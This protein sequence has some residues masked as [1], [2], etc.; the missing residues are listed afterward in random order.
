MGI[1]I[2]GIEILA[3]PRSN[4]MASIYCQLC[5]AKIVDDWRSVFGEKLRKGDL[6]EEPTAFCSYSS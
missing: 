6:K 2:L 4:C 5:N 1:D 3:L